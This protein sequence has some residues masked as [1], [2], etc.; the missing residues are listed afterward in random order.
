MCFHFK[1][2]D[3]IT[4]SYKKKDN[5]NMTEC[6]EY[7]NNAISYCY[8]LNKFS[9]TENIVHLICLDGFI[10]FTKPIDILIY[11]LKT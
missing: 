8:I 2:L 6:V 9:K 5:C 3:G 1:E 11:Y 10:Y 4:F 7:F